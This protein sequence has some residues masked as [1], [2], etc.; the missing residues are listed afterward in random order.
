MWTI[1]LYAAI[2]LIIYIILSGLFSAVLSE[3]EAHP[4]V[5]IIFVSTFS[6]IYFYAILVYF[7][8]KYGAIEIFK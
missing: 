4:I 7:S 3:T 5:Q 6:L 8:S 1:I 2:C